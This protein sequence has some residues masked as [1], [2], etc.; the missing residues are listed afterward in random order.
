[1][2][3]KPGQILFLCT[4]NFYRSRFAEALFNFEAEQRGLGVRAFSR[5]LG[6]EQ[7]DSQDPLSPFTKEVLGKLGIALTYTQERPQAATEE[8]F[9][10]ARALY[11]LKEAEHRPLMR[12]KF[13]AWESLVEYWH[14]AD[15]DAAQPEEALPQIAEKIS[16]LLAGFGSCEESPSR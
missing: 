16:A 11:A 13:P 4:G 3:S 1:M 7:L 14:I 2:S 10:S 9:Q 8:D 15:L 6:L 5:A 12:Q